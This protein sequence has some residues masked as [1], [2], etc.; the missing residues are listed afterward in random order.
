M[1]IRIYSNDDFDNDNNICNDYGV[2]DDIKNSEEKR[3][4]SETHHMFKSNAVNFILYTNLFSIKGLILI[5]KISLI[6]GK[7]ITEYAPESWRRRAQFD[8]NKPSVC[9]QTISHIGVE[10]QR[11]AVQLFKKNQYREQL[12]VFLHMYG[13]E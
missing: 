9:R 10:F 8:E 13:L 2:G 4:L 6:N 12:A 5:P 7:W 3:K 1:M 11:A